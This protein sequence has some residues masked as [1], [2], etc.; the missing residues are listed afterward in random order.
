MGP[1]NQLFLQ[2][3]PLRSLALNSKYFRGTD[4]DPRKELF[5][6]RHLMFAAGGKLTHGWILHT[7]MLTGSCSKC[8]IITDN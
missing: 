2:S 1:R 3:R 4:D 6:F 7:V 5:T 8:L